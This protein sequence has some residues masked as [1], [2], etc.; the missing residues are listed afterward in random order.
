M[1]TASPCASCGQMNPTAVVPEPGVVVCERCRQRLHLRPVDLTRYRRQRP[2]GP[3][4]CFTGP[5]VLGKVLRF[6]SRTPHQG[7]TP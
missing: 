4:P 1:T 7:G 3:V 6:R 5:Q 2:A